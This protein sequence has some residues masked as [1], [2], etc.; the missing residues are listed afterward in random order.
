MTINLFV[1]DKVE[2]ITI[3][4]AHTFHCSKC[5]VLIGMTKESYARYLRIKNIK[6]I[7]HECFWKYKGKVKLTTLNKKQ[8]QELKKYIPDLTEEKMRET[9]S[10]IEN[11]KNDT[12][13]SS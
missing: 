3:E 11:I 5:N 12:T 7:C 13:I 4:N 2:N 6:A 8:M 1:C 9:I 10:N